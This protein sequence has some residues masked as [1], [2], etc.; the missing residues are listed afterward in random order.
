MVAHWYVSVVTF[1]LLLGSGEKHRGYVEKRYV[2]SIKSLVFFGTLMY[3]IRY[4]RVCRVPN[5]PVDLNVPNILITH[6]CGTRD[7]IN[8]EHA[9]SLPKW[10]SIHQEQKVATVFEHC[11]CFTPLVTTDGLT[12]QLFVRQFEH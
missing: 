8:I 2:I 1:G 6:V 5:V 11:C 7:H 3:L 9:Y 10:D 4:V 12:C